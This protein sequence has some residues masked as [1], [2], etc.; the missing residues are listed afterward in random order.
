MNI[1]P[2]LS[3]QDAAGFIKCGQTDLN[4]A[5]DISP[6]GS[7]P[8]P[9][10]PTGSKGRGRKEEPMNP[11]TQFKKNRI[12]PLLIALALVAGAA[13]AARAAIGD[14]NGDGHPDYVLQNACTHRTAIWYLNNNVY[15]GWALGPTL[16]RWWF[17]VGTADF[18]RDG[19]PDYLLLDSSISPDT[20]I[21]YLSGRTLVGT[22]R[23]PSVP[24]VPSGWGW[25]GAG[26]FNGDGYPDYVLYNA[27]TRQ[28]AIWYLRN[29]VY[30]GGG[31]GPTLPMGW[32]V[33]GVADFN[34]DG[35]P[36]YVLEN[37]TGQTAIWYLSGRTR[38]G[39]AYGPSVPSGWALVATADFNG[40]GNP[41]YLLY[42]PSTRQT[43]IWYLNNNV[44]VNSAY[45]P[46]I[47]AGWSLVADWCPPWDYGCCQ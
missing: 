22:A 42:K 39:G 14:F 46:T 10:P 33:V 43:A 12:L 3:R 7:S 25:W 23:G 15:T 36:D 37:G 5:E 4:Q 47:P 21:W 19:H 30:V 18:N 2:R 29:N 6:L 38:A 45:G 40:N 27:T 35:H 13:G 44:Y 11:L 32:V 31:Y 26:D 20:A 9:D 24:R 16:D 34:R 1:R 41:D 17:L 28:T 8:L